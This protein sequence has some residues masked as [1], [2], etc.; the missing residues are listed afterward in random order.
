MKLSLGGPRIVFALGLTLFA[1]TLAS[2]AAGNE[3]LWTDAD[4]EFTVMAELVRVERGNVVLRRED[5][6]EVSVP[7]GKLSDRDRAFIRTQRQKSS[8]AAPKQDGPAQTAE[9]FYSELRSEKREAAIELLTPKA[10]EVVKAAKDKS[11][12]DALP[13]PEEGNRTI[14]VGRA[15]MEGKVATVPVQVRAAG[16]MHKTKVHLRE[17]EGEWL[18]FAIS[19]AY[20]DGEKTFNFEAPPGKEG[21]SPL[22]GLVGQ[23]FALA[24]MT[25]DGNQV[26]L[27][28][29]QGRPVLVTFW[30]TW[31]DACRAEMPNIAANYQKFANKGF[32]VIGVS[33]DEDLEALDSFV[34]KEKP[35]WMVLVDNLGGAR[36]SMA[37]RY[38]INSLPALILVGPDGKVVAVNC[39]GEALGKEL[40]KL[41]ATAQR[42]G[43]GRIR[44][45]SR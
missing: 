35:P 1:G 19:A 29:Y 18:V 44:Y 2:F 41:C 43:D 23:P 24:G 27:S 16:A 12:L 32:D 17:E 4:G 26:D 40:E 42:E 28:K 39:R 34:R 7:L 5:G 36:N 25:L 30:A 6:Q 37:A 10:Q 20:P 22:E 8:A 21:G 3:R 45:A 13:A 9:D 11:P 33:V 38:G 31:C 14:R 15:K